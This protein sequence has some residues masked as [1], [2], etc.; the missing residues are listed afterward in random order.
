MTPQASLSAMVDGS[1]PNLVWLIQK[2]VG[3]QLGTHFAQSYMTLN[4]GVW[5]LKKWLL[6]L[7]LLLSH[8]SFLFISLQGLKVNA[9]ILSGSKFWEVQKVQNVELLQ[10]NLNPSASFQ[11]KKA[12]M[13]FL[14]IALERGWL[15]HETSSNPFLF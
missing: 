13:P 3:V 6:L 9:F 11:Y 10:Q 14:K 15:Q 5:N 4:Q 12:K 8:L 1:S 7:F 2:L